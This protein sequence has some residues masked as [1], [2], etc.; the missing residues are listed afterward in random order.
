MT[1]GTILLLAVVGK[2]NQCMV[3]EKKTFLIHLPSTCVK[4]SYH[5]V[6]LMQSFLAN[7]R[8]IRLNNTTLPQ[9]K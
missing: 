3:I 5:A 2:A 9:S 8:D 1:V 4:C 7:S 6:I